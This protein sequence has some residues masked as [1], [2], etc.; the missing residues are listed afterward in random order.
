MVNHV[1][2][3]DVVLDHYIIPRYL[4][5]TSRLR[6]LRFNVRPYFYAI[7]VLGPVILLAHSLLILDT[8]LENHIKNA[9][10][11][12]KTSQYAY[13]IF[14]LRFFANFKTVLQGGK[15][16]ELFE[17]YSNNFEVHAE[18]TNRSNALLE[19]S[20]HIL[21][22]RKGERAATLFSSTASHF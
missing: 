3:N 2:I 21:H 10:T 12:I 14:E 7:R 8:E 4:T 1:H 18:L 16:L 17:E 6:N 15:C 9:C 11:D 5:V 20:G 19:M 13:H 22:P